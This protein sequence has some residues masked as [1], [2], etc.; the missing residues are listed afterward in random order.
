MVMIFSFDHMTGKNQEYLSN[1][2][3]TWPLG[4]RLDSGVGEAGYILP[5]PWPICWWVVW[6]PAVKSRGEGGVSCS[7]TLSMVVF[8]KF[9]VLNYLVIVRL[10]SGYFS[11]LLN[12]F[13]GFCVDMAPCWSGSCHIHAWRA[14]LLARG[15]SEDFWPVRPSLSQCRHVFAN[16]IRCIF[17]IILKCTLPQNMFSLK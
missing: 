4:F 17:L 15:W 9:L 10:C 2:T 13:W 12:I 14:N 6:G 3:K 5:K 11:P 16:L 8:A 1:F 7:D